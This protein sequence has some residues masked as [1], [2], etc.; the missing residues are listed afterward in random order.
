[1]HFG[2]AF[3]RLGRRHFVHEM[4]VNIEKRGSIRL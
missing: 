2:K 1:M 3:K 4:A